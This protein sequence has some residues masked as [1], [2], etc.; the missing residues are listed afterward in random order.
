LPLPPTLRLPTL[1]TGL[2][3]L[4]RRDGRPAYHWRRQTA[5]AL[6]IELRR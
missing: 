1:I 5:T 3:S 6:Y 4:A 2:E